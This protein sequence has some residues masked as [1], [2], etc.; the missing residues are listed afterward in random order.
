MT[1]FIVFVRILSRVSAFDGPTFFPGKGG[2]RDSRGDLERDDRAPLVFSVTARYCLSRVTVFSTALIS[3]TQKASAVCFRRIQNLISLRR[4]N[5]LIF[6][7]FGGEGSLI[8]LGWVYE[9][10]QRRQRVLHRHPV[11]PFF[12]CA[13]VCVFLWE[14]RTY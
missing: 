12:L 1:F 3:F 8:H 14:F 11:R 4:P 13:C 2:F 9:T 6:V 7:F 5:C 10:V